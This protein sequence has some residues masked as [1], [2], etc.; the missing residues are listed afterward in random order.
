MNK[1]PFGK[2]NYRLMVIGVVII[3]AGFLV[4]SL[5]TE[6]F[7]FGALGLTIGPLLVF[8]GF[9]IEFFAILAKPGQA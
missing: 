1:L 2:K 9:I 7:G 4:M 3:L 5:D 8:A 6:P